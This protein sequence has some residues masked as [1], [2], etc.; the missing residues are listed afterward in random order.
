VQHHETKQVALATP[1][2]RVEVLGH[3]HFVEHLAVV[4]IMGTICQMSDMNALLI[5]EWIRQT[6]KQKLSGP[7]GIVCSFPHYFCHSLATFRPMVMIRAKFAQSLF[8]GISAL[9][10]SIRTSF[11]LAASPDVELRFAHGRIYQSRGFPPDVNIEYTF[12]GL[13]LTNMT[14]PPSIAMPDD[15]HQWLIRENAKYCSF[16]PFSRIRRH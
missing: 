4:K 9:V 2:E 1:I 11:C 14:R 16:I 6:L 10:R 12:V 15:E 8:P 3:L 13:V 5:H 7:C